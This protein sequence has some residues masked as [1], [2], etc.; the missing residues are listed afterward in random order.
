[1]GKGSNE[2]QAL[3]TTH[4]Q[5]CKLPQQTDSVDKLSTM[6]TSEVEKSEIRCASENEPQVVSAFSKK[7]IDEETGRDKE[8]RG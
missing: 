3:W 8:A 1:M 2:Q 7:D 4:K 5:F 6:F